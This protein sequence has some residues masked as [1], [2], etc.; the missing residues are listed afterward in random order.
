MAAVEDLK[1]RLDRL[2]EA[3]QPDP[4]EF[5]ADD[6]AAL[7]EAKRT[8]IAAGPDLLVQVTDDL[9][10]YYDSTVAEFSTEQRAAYGIRDLPKSADIW[11]EVT[12][13]VAP[14]V[15]VGGS[16]HTPARCYLSFEGEVP[17]EPEHGF[18]LVVE[19]GRRVCKLGPYDGHLT[20]AAAFADPSLLRVVFKR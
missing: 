15:T 8:F 13:T 3:V 19:N 10:A 9:W 11:A 2:V 1:Q 20:N 16:A 17:W 4:D 18:Q 5:T 12:I 6:V 14:E 7:A